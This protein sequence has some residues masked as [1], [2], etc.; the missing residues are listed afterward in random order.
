M[1]RRHFLLSALGA[2]APVRAFGQGRPVKVGFL[3]PRPLA[4][5]VYAG[6][7]VRRLAELGYGNVEYRS[8]DGFANRYPKLA[9]ELISLKCEVIVAFGDEHPA[10]ALQDARSPVPLIFLA[11]D[12]DPLEKGLV[13]SLRRPDRNTTG[14]YLPQNEMVAKRV[15][16]MREVLPAARRFL[17]FAD[18]F[19]RDQI[20]AAR[21]AA[22][23][24]RVELTLTEF[25]GQ[26]YDFSGAFQ[27]G[28]EMGAEGFMSLAS[29]V[30][31]ANAPALSAL[32][33]KH[34]RPS[35]GSAAQ[36]AEAGFLLSLNADAA[37]AARRV[38]E[39]AVRILKGTRPADIPVEQAD[40]F[41]LTINTKTAR[42]LGVKIPQSVFARATRIVQ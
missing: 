34:R 22:E 41:E 9:R 26:P 4:E 28:I 1:K 35:I 15:E 33:L 32:A 13:G 19:S 29:P 21:K 36:L 23:A 11:V 20:A 18:V 27:A 31:A 14:V 39:I 10:R 6:S 3:G 37:K 30:F 8:A 5:S 12:Y 16:I 40:E 2:I 7:I 24:A 42:V 25:A 38:A 17:V